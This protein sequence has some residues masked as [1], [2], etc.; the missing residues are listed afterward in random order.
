MTIRVTI[1]CFSVFSFMLPPC[2]PNFF[3]LPGPSKGIGEVSSNPLYFFE[4]RHPRC[5]EPK[6][7]NGKNTVKTQLYLLAMRGWIT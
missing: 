5:V 3:P 2:R 7:Q 1:Y 6:L 4:T